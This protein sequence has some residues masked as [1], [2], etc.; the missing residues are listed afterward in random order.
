MATSNPYK[1]SVIL[2]KFVS[3]ENLG[4]SRGIPYCNNTLESKSMTWKMNK[5]ASHLES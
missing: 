1:N 3:N 5:T 4:I 2:H